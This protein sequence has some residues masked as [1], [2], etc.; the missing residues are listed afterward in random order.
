MR[1]FLFQRRQLL[2]LI[3]IWVG[4]TIYL[5]PLIYALLPLTMF[6]LRS[7]DSWTDLLIGFLMVLVLSDMDPGLVPF[8]AIKSAKYGMMIAIALIYFLDTERFTPAAGIFGFFTPFFIYAFLPLVKSS[9]VVEGASKTISYALLYLVIPNYV[10][11]VFRRDGWTFFRNYFF[12]LVLILVLPYYLRYIQYWWV[13]MAGR[14]HGLFG[15]PNGLGI[16]CFL[17]FMLFFVCTY[18]NKRLFSLGEKALIL[19]VLGWMLI[20][21]GSRTAVVASGLFYFFSRFFALS[22]FIGFVVFLAFAASIEYAQNNLVQIIE[23]LGL[24]KFF[25]VETLASGSGRYFAWNF[26]WEKINSEGFFLTGGGFGNDEYVMRHNYDY[27]RAQG[28]DGGVH[29]SY[30]TMWFNTGLIGIMLYFQG[31]L[32]AFISANKKAPIAFAV[33]FAVLFS[34]LYESWL[35]GSLNPYTIIL[36]TILT[37]LTEDDIVHWDKHKEEMEAGPDVEATAPAP[38]LILPAR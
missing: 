7:Q 34:V 37:L 21:S 31:F 17:N 2:F 35:T 24:Q 33:M 36:L 16:F 6:Y 8:R 14:Y 10:L 13:Y 15:N 19:G 1:A 12:F 5:T 25:R 29:N 28:H 38:Q 11:M 30:L 27:L 4:V 22:P 20:Q 32:S 26:A 9:E 18:L 3:L 23:A